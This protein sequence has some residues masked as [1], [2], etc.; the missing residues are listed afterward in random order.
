MRAQIMPNGRASIVTQNTPG[1]LLLTY[2][3]SNTTSFP[4]LNYH[5]RPS[6]EQASC[7]LKLCTENLMPAA[8]AVPPT[9]PRGGRSQRI[10][11]TV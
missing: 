5:G 11:L 9:P 4:Q 8:V 1:I 2:F 10:F 6:Q 3:V 7:G